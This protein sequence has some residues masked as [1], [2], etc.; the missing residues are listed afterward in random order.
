MLVILINRAKR[1]RHIN[2]V[3]SHLVGDGL[4]ILQYDDDTIIFQDHDVEGVK[5][6]K[7]LLCAFDQLS[8]LKINFHKSEIFFVL[9]KLKRCRGVF[10]YFWM[11]KWY[12]PI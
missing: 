8:G 11:P 6:L 1:E 10:Q 4:L 3:V 12:I 5:K 7:L 2:G 9:G